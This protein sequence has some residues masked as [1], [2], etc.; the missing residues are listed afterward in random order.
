MNE[1]ENEC[2]DQRVELTSAPME[3]AADNLN[4]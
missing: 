1:N 3:Y 2:I 4:G